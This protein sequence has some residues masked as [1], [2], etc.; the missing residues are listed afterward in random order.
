MKNTL[1][2][3]V[4]KGLTKTMAKNFVELGDAAPDTLVPDDAVD[5]AVLASAKSNPLHSLRLAQAKA[6]GGASFVLEAVL[7][8]RMGQR[9]GSEEEEEFNAVAMQWACTHQVSV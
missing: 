9:I 5:A 7:N 4:H 3:Q 2:A 6:F 1:Q 8:A